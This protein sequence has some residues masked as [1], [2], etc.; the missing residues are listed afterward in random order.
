MQHVRRVASKL[1]GRERKRGGNER[2]ERQE[3]EDTPSDSSPPT[4]P[5]A[6]A[7][8]EGLREEMYLCH[9]ELKTRITQEMLLEVMFLVSGRGA[10][11]VIVNETLFN[12]V[13]DAQTLRV[14][15][16]APEGRQ[17]LL[18]GYLPPPGARWFYVNKN[19]HP[20][21]HEM[22]L[23]TFADAAGTGIAKVGFN[24]ITRCL[25]VGSTT[26]VI[27]VSR[28]LER[29]GFEYDETFEVKFFDPKVL[30]E[31]PFLMD[32]IGRATQSVRHS[33]AMLAGQRAAFFSDRLKYRDDLGGHPVREW[34]CHQQGGK[35]TPVEEF[36]AAE[37]KVSN[38]ITVAFVLY[39][40]SSAL[41]ARVRSS[42]HWYIR[43]E[44]NEFMRRGA[45]AIA[46]ALR[47]G[48]GRFDTFV[49]NIKFDPKMCA[50][51]ARQAVVHVGRDRYAELDEANTIQLTMTVTSN[52]ANAK[53]DMHEIP[54]PSGMQILV[55]DALEVVN[56]FKE[57]SNPRVIESFVAKVEILLGP[58]RKPRATGVHGFGHLHRNPPIATVLADKRVHKVVCTDGWVKCY[59]A[60]SSFAD[61]DE[62]AV[63]KWMRDSFRLDT[64]CVVPL[65]EPPPDDE[66]LM[67]PYSNHPQFRADFDKVF[68]S[69][70]IQAIGVL[71][72][73]ICGSIQHDAEQDRALSEG[74]C[75]PRGRG[76]S[77]CATT[78]AASWLRARAPAGRWR[79]AAAL[80]V[81]ADQT[82]SHYEAKQS[83]NA[84]R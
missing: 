69:Q 60:T 6:V 74:R 83:T 30:D 36:I 20:W 22:G 37:G 76:C 49:K 65:L 31:L 81:D 15:M 80:G 43:E 78:E 26:N 67:L 32:K 38:T 77:R 34:F 62:D 63:L 51:Q 33:L 64:V 8:E 57:K 58:K 11:T 59:E 46:G 66:S 35:A 79:G 56:A 14:T 72:E 82:T 61:V 48:P 27:G 73:I 3:A 55:L 71:H 52:A 29:R 39:G 10:E 9:D 4:A 16:E 70:A 2:E 45:F 44:P 42:W 13:K 7:A 5:V 84:R 21:I 17:V 41:N 19:V 50:E 53:Q 25:H 18:L 47:H 12:Q 54:F 68:Q 75:P 24:H 23:K 28:K 40:P 1:L